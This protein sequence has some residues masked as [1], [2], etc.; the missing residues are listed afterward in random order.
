MKKYL[1]IFNEEITEEQANKFIKNLFKKRYTT[2]NIK[3]EIFELGKKGEI[4]RI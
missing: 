1:F 4:K 3:V 2:T